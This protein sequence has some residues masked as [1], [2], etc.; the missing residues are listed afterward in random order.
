M[1]TLILLF[2]VGIF[3]IVA[4]VIVPGGILA[5]IGGLMMFGG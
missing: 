5:A 1:T 4:E 3:L 2:V